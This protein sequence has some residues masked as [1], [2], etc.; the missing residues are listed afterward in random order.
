MFVSSNAFSQTLDLF[1]PLVPALVVPLYGN[2]S[3]GYVC[4]DGWWFND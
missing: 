4:G 3:V 1:A 2:L